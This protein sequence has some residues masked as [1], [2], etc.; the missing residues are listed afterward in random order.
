MGYRLGVDIGGTFTDFALVDDETGE[1][2]IHKQLTTPA[3]P[4]IAV[5]EGTEALLGRRG[6][7]AAAVGTVIHGSTLVTNA[8]IE[9]K[10]APTGMLV[11]K[12]FRDVLDIAMER[13]YDL[14][15]LTIRFPEPIVPR[16]HRIEIDERLQFDGEVLV[17]CDTDE[18]VGAVQSLLE[19]HGIEA[20][21]I[22]FL[23]SFVSPVHEERA[24]AAVAHAF[25]GLYVSTS[26]DVFPFARE[27]ERWNTTA[28]N[29]FVQPMADRYLANLEDGLG[30]LGV[31]GELFIMTASAGTVTT[32]T[33]RRYPVRM[34]E[35]G[36]AAGVLM[37][38]HH[39]RALGLANVLSYDM[40]G[41]TAKGSIVR[42]GTPAKNY[43]IEVARI[44]NFKQGSG[45]PVKIPVIDMIEIGSGGG[46]IAA[47]DDRGVIRV[48]PESAGADPG[49]ACYG[50][51]GTQATLTDADL[52]LGY[53]DPAFFLG[54]R[55][56]LDRPAA[57]AAIAE[58]IAGPLG[59]DVARA[60]WGIHEVINED[61]ARA[62]RVHASEAGFD[63]RD[64]SMVAFGGAGPVHALRIARK[65]GIPSVVLP[66]GAGVM[67]AFGM[68]VSPLSF[69]L[70][71]S[72]R[73][74][75]DDWTAADFATFLD[76][77]TTEASDFLLR[78]GVGLAEITVHRGLDMRYRG[79]GYEIEVDLPATDDVGGLFDRLPEL[80]ARSYAKIFSVSYL[81]EPI[82]IINWKVEVEGPPP[83]MRERFHLLAERPAGAARKG[84]RDAYFPEAD[85]FVDA[86]VYD[87]YALQSGMTVDGP[88]LIEENESTCV[89]GIGDAVRVNADGSLI[90]EIG[91]GREQP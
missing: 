53:L 19:H 48:G 52:V 80:F 77:L 29:A 83:P 70:A 9:R 22:C 54:G 90:A 78:A 37:S 63:Y 79:Q 17:P 41:T 24:R 5:L 25:P 38:A 89:V 14:Y 7:P 46:G 73:G 84:S 85:G 3:D 30:A 13:R 68:L 72:N 51:G 59:V 20:L 55:M 16:S 69:Q 27:Y 71:K 6:V 12:G 60:A 81:D 4:S 58:C 42:A 26:A 91:A 67:S 18:V 88:A 33:A 76:R 74:L 66:A 45:L 50:R 34:M 21:A 49:P 47:V 61:V 57:A 2:A 56:G 62:F 75:L 44:H 23:H 39:G 32:E 64:C 65:L 87:R 82:E 8:V 11:T 10:G 36:P 1:L 43:Q 31:A 86:A 35:S 40:G 28:I 15:D